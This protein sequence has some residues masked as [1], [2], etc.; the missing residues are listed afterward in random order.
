MRVYYSGLPLTHRISPWNGTSPPLNT[1][2][3]FRSWVSKKSLDFD[4]SDGRGNKSI[5]Q[6]DSYSILNQQVTLFINLVPADKG[7]MLFFVSYQ[8]SITKANSLGFRILHVQSGRHLTV[9][10]LGNDHRYYLTTHE[11]GS[12]FFFEPREGGTW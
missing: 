10:Q 11:L 12:I 2:V 9:G 3:R 4:W 8:W 7:L 5:H 6:F 1:P